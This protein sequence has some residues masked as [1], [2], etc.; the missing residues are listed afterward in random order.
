MYFYRIYDY[1][2]GKEPRYV[3]IELDAGRDPEP[4]CTFVQG[5]DLLTLPGFKSR[6]FQPV[7]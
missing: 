4:V 3:S 1:C 2:S 5:R 7:S 6:I